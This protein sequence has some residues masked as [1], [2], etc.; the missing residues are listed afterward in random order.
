MIRRKC[1]DDTGLSDLLLVDEVLDFV[2]VSIVSI[3][4]GFCPK[5]FPLATV[6]L[7]VTRRWMLLRLYGLSAGMIRR[8]CRDD[9]A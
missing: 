4:L 6:F 7:L 2:E 3:V 8:K 1:R 5:G 9:T